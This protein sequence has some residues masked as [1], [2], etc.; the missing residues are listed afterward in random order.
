MAFVVGAVVGLL[1]IPLIAQL[2]LEVER[3]KK[4]IVTTMKEV[5][6]MVDFN[7]FLLVSIVVGMSVG[8]HMIYRPVYLTELEGSKTL[9]GNSALRLI[10]DVEISEFHS[11][12]SGLLL[13]AS[14]IGSMVVLSLIKTIIEKLGEPNTIIVTLVIFCLRSVVYYFLQ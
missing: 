5:S 12:S 7:I 2:D 6:G 10:A 9:I 14:G 3:N 8:F 1:T 4:S 13:S 11:I